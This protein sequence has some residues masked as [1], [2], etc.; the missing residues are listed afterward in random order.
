MS[1]LTRWQPTTTRWNPFKD[2]ED[3]E[4]RVIVGCQRVK[5]DMRN[6]LAI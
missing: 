4:K 5:S 2:L 3:M 1:D 6:L